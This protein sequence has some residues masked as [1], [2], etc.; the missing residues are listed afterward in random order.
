[1]YESVIFYIDL[2]H[3]EATLFEVL[4]KFLL[5]SSMQQEIDSFHWQMQLKFYGQTSKVL[6]LDHS[7]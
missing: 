6:R 5:K 1:L 4:N 7:F 2:T 3:F